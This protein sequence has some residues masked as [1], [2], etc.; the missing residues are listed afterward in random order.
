MSSCLLAENESHTPV[1]ARSI[2]MSK[3]KYLWTYVIIR[4]LYKFQ[5]WI[6]AKEKA[7]RCAFDRQEEGNK[8]LPHLISNRM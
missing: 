1:T 4:A 8:H 2:Q 7:T 3:A 6:Y 5:E